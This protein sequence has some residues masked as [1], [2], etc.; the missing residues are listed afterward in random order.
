MKK[1]TMDVDKYKELVSLIYDFKAIKSLKERLEIEEFILFE[2]IREC[3]EVLKIS[4][5]GNMHYKGGKL[6][7]QYMWA[8]GGGST[9]QKKRGGRLESMSEIKFNRDTE[10]CV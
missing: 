7:R 5:K 6:G 9:A 1:I 4:L 2:R 10:E 3:K 8:I